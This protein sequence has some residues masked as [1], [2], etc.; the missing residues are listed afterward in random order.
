MG[1]ITKAYG[2]LF[3]PSVIPPI[4]ADNKAPASIPAI[5]PKAAVRKVVYTTN[6]VRN[7]FAIRDG[8]VFTTVPDH[9]IYLAICRAAKFPS[10]R[11]T[12]E[13]SRA[14][15]VNHDKEFDNYDC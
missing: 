11:A 8:T 4:A 12:G 5:D 2:S 14:S 15:S 9:H 10:A 6:S 1:V 7:V 3:T 13:L